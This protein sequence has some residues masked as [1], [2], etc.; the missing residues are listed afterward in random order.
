MSTRVDALSLVA[1]MGNFLAL[2]HVDAG[3]DILGFI[4]CIAV[5]TSIA[6]IGSRVRLM[7]IVH[8][9]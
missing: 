2:V 3:V 8:C 4:Q 7:L 9:D 5:D 1:L 6:R